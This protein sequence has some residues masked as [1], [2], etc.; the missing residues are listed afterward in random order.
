MI[1]LQRD[2]L[3][4]L[5]EH[6]PLT[7]INDKTYPSVVITHRMYRLVHIG[8]SSILTE[9]ITK[10]VFM[11][12]SYFNEMREFSFKSPSIQTETITKSIPM[13]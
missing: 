10:C 4:H 2:G 3:V 9:S 11:H 6:F 7:R 13:Y 8:E 1:L 12:F 5:Q